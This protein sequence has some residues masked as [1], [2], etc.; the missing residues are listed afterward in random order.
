MLSDEETGVRRFRTDRAGGPH[1]QYLLVVLAQPEVHVWERRP[2][3]RSYAQL[4]RPRVVNTNHLRRN[5]PRTELKGSPH[6]VGPHPRRAPAR[7]AFVWRARGFPTSSSEPAPH[8]APPRLGSCSEPRARGPFVLT[9]VL[10]ED[11][12]FPALVGNPRLRPTGTLP[13]AAFPVSTRAWPHTQGCLTP[14]HGPQ[15]YIKHRLLISAPAPR[16]LAP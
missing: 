10:W 13:T 8:R 1:L 9:A 15:C 11:G 5:V 6:R 3:V 16:D 14:V 7:W 4:F 2:G 12:V